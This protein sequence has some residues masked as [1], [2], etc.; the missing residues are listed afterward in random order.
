MSADLEP[1]EV[2]AILESSETDP[3]GGSELELRDFSRPRRL[4]AQRLEALVRDLRAGGLDLARRLKAVL[5]TA[6]DVE[7]LEVHEVAADGLLGDLEEPCCLVEFDVAGQPGWIVWQVEAAIRAIEVVLGTAEAPDE[8][9][10]RRLS[11]VELGVAERL[12]G[13]L[14]AGVCAALGVEA[15]GFRAVPRA[16]LATDWRAPGD[17]ADPARAAVRLQLHE[18]ERASEVRLYV[19]G[20]PTGAR[21]SAHPAHLDPLPAH[22]REVQLDLVGHLGSVDVPLAQLLSLEVGDVI[23][24]RA[25]VGTPLRVSAEGRA[26]AEAHLGTV[27]GQLGLSILRMLSPGDDEVS[28]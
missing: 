4:G 25:P 18:G 1:E 13:A 6:G 11:R 7:L 21:D 27:S 22:L 26:W 8:V 9:E 10:L 14:G 17:S 2:Q 15:T 28:P 3:R 5:P 16:E 12:L 24:L 20:V 19:P 23:P